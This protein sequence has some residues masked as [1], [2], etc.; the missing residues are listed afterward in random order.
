MGR[1]RIP[2]VAAG[3][4][5]AAALLTARATPAR[6]QAPP[7]G[8]DTAE[9][10]ITVRAGRVLGPVN[11]LVLG[12]N[13]E[14][15]DPQDLFISWSNPIPGRTGE[16]LW[17]PAK[18]GPVPETVEFA[19][20]VGMGMLRYPGGCLV[21]NFDWKAAVGPPEQRP[22]FTFGVSEFIAYCRAVG[23]EPLMMVSAYVGGP[24]DAADLVEYLNAP[25]TA[26]HPWAQK[27]A[28]WGHPEPYGVVYFEMG[29]ESDHGNHDVKPF[30]KH[31]AE[32]YAGWFNECS[33][34]MRAV[35]PHIK[36]GALLA[37]TMD[38][39]SAW[40]PVVLDRVKDTAD[41]IIVHTYPVGVWGDEVAAM[42]PAD[43][44]MR[45]CMAA[46]DQMAA[47][48][49]DYRDVIRRHAGR[50]IPLAVTEYNGMF[51]QE[52][53]VPYRF[54]YGPALFSA[55]YVRVML[56]PEANVLMA[57]YWHFVNGY[58]G[59]LRGP[60][61]P[62]EG[63]ATWRKMPAFHLYRLWGQHFGE[64][65]V[66]VEVA[67]PRLGFKGAVNTRPAYGEGGLPEGT[68]PDA[69][70]LEGDNFTTG[71]GNGWSARLTEDGLLVMELDALGAES[72]P[73]A[74]TVRPLRP[75]AYTL[76]YTGRFVG[77]ARGARLGLGLADDRGWEATHSANAVDGVEAAA[78][79]AAFSGELVTLPD[80]TGLHVV[81]R[82][83]PGDEPATGRIEV[84][85]LRLRPAPSFPAYPAL[86]ATAS[87]SADRRT[88]FLIVFNKHHAE[89]IETE[90]AVEGFRVA[91]ARAWTV[92]GPS[93]DALNLEEEQVREVESGAEVDQ[94]GPAGFRRTFPARSMTAI[95]LTRA[96]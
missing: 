72:Y 18:R 40:N 86:T 6:A 7:G 93:L 50:D 25:A 76:S 83:V 70:L 15:A 22:N 61:V 8:R 80:C 53:P 9:A 34:R 20:Q 56:R 23:A 48:L 24:Q 74:T 62:G 43:R 19:R 54:A 89:G 30:R 2:A 51:V 32:S 73:L 78:E 29:N 87:L 41:F 37:T 17:D 92:T 85:D 36:M 16:G 21:H 59:M 65:L 11:R 64:E 46:G 26:D 3:V 88:L 52:R 66:D 94:V 68:D 95:E 27:R 79:W 5:L 90:V 77:E 84:R 47:L 58:W 10:T 12:H 91:A 49:A 96:D 42:Y 38:P 4:V 71:A 31:T 35:D 81:W 57:N 67:G 69:D 45:A 13:V 14:A 63:P 75:G 60:Q 1:A 55:D 44:L 39:G 82:L 33:R 28:A